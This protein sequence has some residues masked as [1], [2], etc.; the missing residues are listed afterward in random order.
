MFKRIFSTPRV[1]YIPSPHP[2][3]PPPRPL[4]PHPPSRK[5][6]NGP[7]QTRDQEMVQ[8][9]HVTW[10]TSLDWVQSRH[11]TQVTC[12]DSTIFCRPRAGAGGRGRVGV[13][14][15]AA[16]GVYAAYPLSCAV[17]GIPAKST[18]PPPARAT[19]RASALPMRN[20]KN[21][22]GGNL[23]ARSFS[24]GRIRNTRRKTTQL[25]SYAA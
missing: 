16:V 9:R 25:S 19:K 7:I 3:H 20:R 13:L 11:V 10:V 14:G 5:P 18:T 8:S 15:G 2:C 24:G 4:P 6:G 22:G 1:Y 12:L 23:G 17:L 21:E